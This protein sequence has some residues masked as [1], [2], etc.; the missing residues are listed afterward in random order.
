MTGKTVIMITHDLQSIA[1][2]DHVLLLEDGRVSAAGTHQELVATSN[3]Y[4]QLYEL[5][6]SSESPTR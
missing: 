6:A 4:R 2:A 5:K 3:R 1:D